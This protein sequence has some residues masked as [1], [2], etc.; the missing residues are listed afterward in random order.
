MKSN[1]SYFYYLLE[2]SVRVCRKE[3]PDR[4]IMC[5]MRYVSWKVRLHRRIRM[6]PKPIATGIFVLFRAFIRQLIWLLNDVYPHKY[7]DADPYKRIYVDPSSIEYTSGASRRRGWVI[8][9]DWDENTT[10]FMQRT[11]PKMIEQRYSDGLEL[12]ETS[13]A[14]KHDGPELEERAAAIDRLYQH[15]RDEGY[16]SQ[17]QLLEDSPETAWNGLNDAMHPLANEVAVD[18]GRD[19]KLLWNMCGQHRLAIANVLEI[20]RIPVQ[21]FRRHAEWQAIR[22]RARRGEDVP[23]EYR[24]HP[25]LT[26]VL[27][28]G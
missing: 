7:T 13:L 4:V 9:G 2:R 27:E 22:D 17:R 1:M 3:G 25:D 14:D 26:D 5:G 6:L 23:E 15:I 18:I 20:G 12:D 8:D 19:G 28:N 24:D 11:Y 21:V 10:R 16:K